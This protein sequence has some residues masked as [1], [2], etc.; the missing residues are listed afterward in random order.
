MIKIFTIALGLLWA[1]LALAVVRDNP[2]SN[3]FFD[4]G[5]I[6]GNTPSGVI[7][8][9]VGLLLGLAAI[10]ATLL[11]IIGGVQYIIS[12]TNEDLAKRGKSTVTSAVVGLIIIILSYTIITV[13]IRVLENPPSAPIP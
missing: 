6:G 3:L 1:D 13:V 4:I 12:G 2:A 7:G 10:V 5:G 11:I 9:L 8:G